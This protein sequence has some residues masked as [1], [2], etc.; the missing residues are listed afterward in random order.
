MISKKKLSFSKINL[1]DLKNYFDIK[2]T[3]TKV[4][5][6]D[7][8]NYSYSLDETE[9]QVLK[10]LIERHALRLGAY[11]E[12]K[13]KVKF[14]GTILNQVNFLTNEIDDWYEVSIEHEFEN[15]ILTGIADYLV[16]A[17]TKEPET[18]YF[19]L[20][21]FKA[22]QPDQDPEVQLLAQ[23]I[24]TLA[25]NESQTIKGGYILGQLWKFAILEKIG[26]KSYHYYVSAS[27]DALIYEQLKQI[28]INLQAV[29]KEAIELTKI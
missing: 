10:Q 19:F 18:P 21:E 1:K 16:A 22:S 26:D 27:F 4:I 23:M 12:E 3:Y 15:V 28:Y 29:K 14:I 13:L 8:F 6:R 25:H 17:G 20:Q 11:K 24:A 2:I 7:W 5:F 9:Q